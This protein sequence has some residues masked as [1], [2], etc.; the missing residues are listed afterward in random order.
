MVVHKVPKQ[1]CPLP[2]LCP[3]N[4]IGQA[5][6]HLAL[7]HLFLFLSCRDQYAL[8]WVIFSHEIERERERGWGW[9]VCESSVG[10]LQL[11]HCD[12]LNMAWFSTESSVLDEPLHQFGHQHIGSCTEY[13]QHGASSK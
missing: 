8:I 1:L 2:A 11:L 6:G 3:A 5:I 10:D 12:R 4:Y 7:I 13:I 9:I